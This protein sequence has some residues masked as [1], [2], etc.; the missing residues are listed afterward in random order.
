M[1]IG[2]LIFVVCTLQLA[3]NKAFIFKT[4]VKAHKSQLGWTFAIGATLLRC[5]FMS[6]AKNSIFYMVKRKMVL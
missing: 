2:T 3:A 6:Q 5:H 4:G 1:F